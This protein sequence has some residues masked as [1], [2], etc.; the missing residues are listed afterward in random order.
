MVGMFRSFRETR[1]SMTE[2]LQCLDPVYLARLVSDLCGSL[3][4][5]GLT[6]HR[7]FDP[8]AYRA[9]AQSAGR[10]PSPLFDPDRFAFA[11]GSMF[12]ICARDR[13]GRVVHLQ[14]TRLDDTAAGTLADFLPAL[15]RQGWNADPPIV[16]CPLLSRIRGRIAYRGDFWR[17]PGQDL[18]GVAA[19]LARLGTVYAFTTWRTAP[20][21][22]W[23]VFERTPYE[24]GISAKAWFQDTAPVGRTWQGWLAADEWFGALRYEDFVRQVTLAGVSPSPAP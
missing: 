8:D 3:A 6:L 13:D 9:V 2:T 18:K 23:A 16:D 15:F 12:W 4:A 11:A 19:D 10:T 1:P 7:S 14:A 21:Y 20:E 5:R 22:C 24:I 17:A